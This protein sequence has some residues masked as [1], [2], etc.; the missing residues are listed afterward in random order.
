MAR[1]APSEALYVTRAFHLN[2]QT[3]VSTSVMLDSQTS[4]QPLQPTAGCGDV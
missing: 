2:Q 1:R 4:N 3:T